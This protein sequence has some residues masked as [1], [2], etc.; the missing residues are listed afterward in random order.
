MVMG[1]GPGVSSTLGKKGLLRVSF[2]MM[3]MAMK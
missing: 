3:M 1:L 2:R